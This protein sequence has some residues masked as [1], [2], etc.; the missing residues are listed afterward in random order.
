MFLLIVR[1][2]TKPHHWRAVHLRSSW[3]A[4]DV[5]DHI[6]KSTEYDG[7][8]DPGLNV[9]RMVPKLE[10]DKAQITDV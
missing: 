10:I 5:N 2:K 3:C 6:S 4:W 1:P 9:A 7:P 8:T